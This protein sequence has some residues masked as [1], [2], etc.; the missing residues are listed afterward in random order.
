MIG[1]SLCFAF[2]PQEAL[3]WLES[4][5]RSCPLQHVERVARARMFLVVSVGCATLGRV[6]FTYQE[7]IVKG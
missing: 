2:L 5:P 3:D 4:Q 1:S 7:E 6:D